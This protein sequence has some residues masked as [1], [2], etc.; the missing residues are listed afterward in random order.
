MF[1][2]HPVTTSDKRVNLP[3]TINSPNFWNLTLDNFINRSERKVNENGAYSFDQDQSRDVRVDPNSPTDTL[4]PRPKDLPRNDRYSTVR[5]YDKWIYN[6]NM[7]IINKEAAQN[8]IP[9][10]S[11]PIKE[12]YNPELLDAIKEF[13]RGGGTRQKRTQLSHPD[14][15]DLI[16]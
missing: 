16:D 11:R 3:T 7:D 1:F 6:L 10:N 8:T 9:Y 14:D 4:L 5:D 13:I 2:Q 12:S 15:K